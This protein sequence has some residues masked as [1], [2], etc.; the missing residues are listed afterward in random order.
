MLQKHFTFGGVLV[1]AAVL[2][3]ATAGPSQ[4]AGRVGGAH[5]GGFHA[6]YHAGFY[7]GGYH[8]QPYQ[9]YGHYYHGYY[10]RSWGYGYYPY[11]H[12]YYPYGYGYYPYSYG[13]YPYGYDYSSYYSSPADL[14][15]WYP[16]AG[17]A[18]SPGVTTAGFTSVSP[19]SGGGGESTVPGQPDTTAHLTLTVPAGANVWVDGTKTYSAGPVRVL[20]SPPLAPGSDY[21]YQI[22]ARWKDDDGREVT[23]TQQVIVTAGAHVSAQFPVRAA[24]TARVSAAPE[25]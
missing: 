3:L 7:H 21:K 24:T 10:P 25:R 5:F 23:Q 17:D 13:S 2:A 6:G 19:L 14:S 11:Y 20:Q 12:N 18:Y 9:A 1:L 4:A 22:R 8:Y 15:P 16:G